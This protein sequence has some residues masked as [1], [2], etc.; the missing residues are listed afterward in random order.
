MALPLCC[1]RSSCCCHLPCPPLPLPSRPCLP[2]PSCPCPLALALTPPS[3]LCLCH[4]CPLLP[5]S[6]T[7]AIAAVNNHHQFFRTVEDKNHQNPL[8]IVSHQGRQWQS[9]SSAAAVDGCGSDGIFDA[10]INDND[11]RRTVGSIPPPPPSTTTIVN[12]DRHCRHH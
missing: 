11:R 8:D 4:P 2:S 1:P 7:T 12:E 6:T 3:S 10:A 9:L 5:L